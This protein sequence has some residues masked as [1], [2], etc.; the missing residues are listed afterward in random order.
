MRSQGLTGPVQL[1]QYRNPAAP[2]PLRPTPSGGAYFRSRIEKARQGT[3][4]R[5]IEAAKNARRGSSTT[6]TAQ[7]FSPVRTYAKAASTAPTRTPQYRRP[8]QQRER[9]NTNKYEST[10]LSS[11]SPVTET[12]YVYDPNPSSLATRTMP[13]MLPTTMGTI[14]DSSPKTPTLFKPDWHDC[15]PRWY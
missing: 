11:S 4:M 12:G 2:R 9:Y 7:Q 10:L 8:A 5:N 15:E 13:Y 14:T 1:S 3:L 6:T